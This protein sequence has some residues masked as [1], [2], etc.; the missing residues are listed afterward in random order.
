MAG[1]PKGKHLM[2]KK[3]YLSRDTPKPL[4]HFILSEKLKSLS[5]KY[6]HPE[7]CAARIMINDI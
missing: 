6:L 2:V 3:D 5:Y 4:L 7:K 1:H